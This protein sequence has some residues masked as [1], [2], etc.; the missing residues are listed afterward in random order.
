M[1]VEPKGRKLWT[2]QNVMVDKCVKVYSSLNIF[3]WGG[4]VAQRGPWPP[5]S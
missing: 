1:L 5:R 2:C 4:A 3:F